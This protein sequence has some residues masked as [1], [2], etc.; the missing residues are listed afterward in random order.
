MLS[1]INMQNLILNK[2]LYKTQKKINQYLRSNVFWIR[3]KCL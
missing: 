3:D 1:S 2:Y